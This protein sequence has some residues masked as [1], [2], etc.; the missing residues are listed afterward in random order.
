M[1]LQSS[2]AISLSQLQ[3]EFGGGNPI[4]MSEYYRGGSYVPATK[5]TSTRQPSSGYNYSGSTYWQRRNDTEYDIYWVKIFWGGTNV[6]T[7]NG[8]SQLSATSISTGGLD[9]L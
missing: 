8:T 5:T 4:H 1:A 6:Y 2:G 9:V 3:A 7:S